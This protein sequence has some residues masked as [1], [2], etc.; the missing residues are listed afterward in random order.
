MSK[1]ILSPRKRFCAATLHEL[2]KAQRQ[3]SGYAQQHHAGESSKHRHAASAAM[4]HRVDGFI[5]STIELVEK[6]MARS[7]EVEHT[8]VPLQ[9]C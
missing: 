8:V 2:A 7:E 9:D 1:A 6:V 3:I 4:R 5:E